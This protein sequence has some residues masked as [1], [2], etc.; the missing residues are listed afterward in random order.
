MFRATMCPSSGADGCIVL[1]PCVGIV[2][3]LEEGCQKRLAG[4]VSIEEFLSLTATFRTQQQSAV[5]LY[6]AVRLPLLPVPVWAPAKSLLFGD[7]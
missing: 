3:W 5:H 1:S 4:S 2:P 6:I 7:I